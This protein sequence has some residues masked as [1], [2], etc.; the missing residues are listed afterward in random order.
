[1]KRENSEE[2]M[3]MAGLRETRLTMP[4]RREMMTGV[5]APPTN[6]PP[7]RPSGMPSRLSSSACRRIMR[8]IWEGVVP[9]VLSR[10]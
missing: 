1:M 8:E 7:T 9:M 6:Q 3:K 5:S 10:P 4:S 2:T